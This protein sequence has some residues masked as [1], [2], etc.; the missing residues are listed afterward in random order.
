[1]SEYVPAELRRQVRERSGY[2]CEY[3]LLHED[4]S[5]LPHEPDHIIA[6]K[7]R[8]ETTE[9]NLAWTCFVC[10]RGKGSD[11]ASVDDV[12]GAIVRLYNPRTDTWEEHMVLSKG[13]LGYCEDSDWA[14]HCFPSQVE[15]TGAV[16]YQKAHRHLRSQAALNSIGR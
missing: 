1:M 7:H 4:D 9:G 16:S 14:S 5:F 6:V 13:W 12:T 11:I 10:N 15:S 2:R 3:C 8:G